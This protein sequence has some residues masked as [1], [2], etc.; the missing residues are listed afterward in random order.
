[1]SDILT[2]RL[3]VEVA[4]S[5]TLLPVSICNIDNDTFINVT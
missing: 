1:M 5:G 3:V 2:K 4:G